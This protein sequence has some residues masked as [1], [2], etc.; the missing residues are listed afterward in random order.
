MKATKIL[1][2]EIS[3]LKISS[4]PSRPTALAAYGGKGYSSIQ[5]K[6]AFDAL[7]LFIIK[8]LNL[9]LDDISAEGADS[10]AEVIKTGIRENMSLAN[11][12]QSISDGSFLSLIP[13]GGSTLA[14]YLTQLRDDLDRVLR[15]LGLESGEGGD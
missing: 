8:R 3:E 12:C 9:L 10:V 2:G 6:A 5:M 1:D 7:P 13:V 4:L 11:L 15:A 14:V